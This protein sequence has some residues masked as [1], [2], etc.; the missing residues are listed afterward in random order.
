MLLLWLHLTKNR[1][2]R[3]HISGVTITGV[4]VTG[5]VTIRE[6]ARGVVAHKGEE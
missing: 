4:R 3:V 1:V 5:A 6:E 2:N